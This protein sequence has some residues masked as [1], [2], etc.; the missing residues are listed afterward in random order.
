M[1]TN[2]NEEEQ[3]NEEN[4]YYDEQQ[5]S[6]MNSLMEAMAQATKYSAV[7]EMKQLKQDL[8][9]ERK[10]AS[11][12][13]EQVKMKMKMQKF[14]NRRMRNAQR[15]RDREQKAQKDAQSKIIERK[16]D[17][18]NYANQL[19]HESK[20]KKLLEKYDHEDDCRQCNYEYKNAEMIIDEKYKL[21]RLQKKL[22]FQQI[23]Y[24]NMLKEQEEINEIVQSKTN[25]KIELQKIRYELV[26][27][28]GPK[29]PKDYFQ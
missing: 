8:E 21:D 7:G 25:E 23:R 27:K 14:K 3:Y 2:N 10:Q 29:M 15:Q 20:K 26:Q 12:M 17:L 19:Q 4:Y 16:R 22:Q 13:N 5:Q 9:I 18:E 1:A 6:G 11:I 24:N 28:Y